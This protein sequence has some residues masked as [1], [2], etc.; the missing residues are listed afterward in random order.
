MAKIEKKVWPEYFEKI[1]TGDKKYELRLADFNCQ[2]GD[3]LFLKEWDP[4]TKQ[5]TGRSL[6][7]EATFIIRT[8]DLKFWEPEDVEKCGFQIISFK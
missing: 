6:E 1:L 2:P 5:Y 4:V 3:I 7:K 8:K